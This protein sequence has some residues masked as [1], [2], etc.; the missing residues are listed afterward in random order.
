MVLV[1]ALSSVLSRGEI[2]QGRVT[3]PPIVFVLEVADDYAGLGQARPVI[4]VEALP[5]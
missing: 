5:S 3:M 2:T 1:A 4:A